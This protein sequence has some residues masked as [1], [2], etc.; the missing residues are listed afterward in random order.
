[1]NDASKDISGRHKMKQAS[2]LRRYHVNYKRFIKFNDKLNT[3]SLQKY[4]IVQI[5]KSD[6]ELFK[7]CLNITSTFHTITIFESFINQNNYSNKTCT[8]VHDLLRYQ[9]S[10]D[11]VQ[12]IMSC[13]HKTKYEF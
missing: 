8:H 7:V 13:L 3:S 11:Y 2:E 9:T 10:I 5:I 6:T 12:R 1:V 4:V